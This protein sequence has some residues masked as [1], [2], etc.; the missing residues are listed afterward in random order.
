MSF[1]FIVVAM[2]LAFVKLVQSHGM[3]LLAWAV[4]ALGVALTFWF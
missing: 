2:V 4:L 3:D 1:G